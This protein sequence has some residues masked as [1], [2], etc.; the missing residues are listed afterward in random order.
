MAQD[1]TPEETQE[2]QTQEEESTEETQEEETQD[3]SDQ[4]EES[5]EES[6]GSDDSDDTDWKAE[7]QKWKRIATKGSKK[8]ETP[9]ITKSNPASDERIERL[10]LKQDGYSDKVIDQIMELGG[11]SA[12]KNEVV[13]TAVESLVQQESTEKAADV[14]G[15]SQSSTKSTV[16]IDELKGMSAKEMEKHLPKS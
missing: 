9:K 14:D 10:E 4:Q 1:Q 8:K 16:T 12:L 2:Q 15:A 3:D 5:E 13:K 11:K 6:S 7:A